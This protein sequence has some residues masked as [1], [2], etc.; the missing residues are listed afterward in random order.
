MHKRNNC[1]AEALDFWNGICGS[2]S[3]IWDC[4]YYDNALAPLFLPLSSCPTLSSLRML[5]PLLF[6]LAFRACVG[7][8][9]ASAWCSVTL[10]SPDANSALDMPTCE[11][12]IGRSSLARIDLK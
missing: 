10:D 5:F 4:S 7:T 11:T 12:G 6:L 9:P 2:R 8:R 1:G 3:A